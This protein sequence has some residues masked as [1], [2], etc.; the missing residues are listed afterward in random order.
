MLFFARSTLHLKQASQGFTTGTGT[1]EKSLGLR[2]FEVLLY[3][4]A[5]WLEHP[6]TSHDKGSLLIWLFDSFSAR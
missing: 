2:E 6:A 1:S 3:R 4:T 5:E